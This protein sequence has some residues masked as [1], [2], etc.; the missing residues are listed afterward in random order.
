MF[1]MDELLGIIDNDFMNM[2]VGQSV[3][4]HLS[5]GLWAIEQRYCLYVNKKH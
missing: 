1:A 3:H 4:K 2:M 5:H